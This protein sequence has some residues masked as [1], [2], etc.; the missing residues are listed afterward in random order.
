MKI[1]EFK[2]IVL[3]DLQD[4]EDH[5]KKGLETTDYYEEDNTLEEWYEQIDGYLEIRGT[6]W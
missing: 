6:E 4:F 2:K 3:Q 1:D 5:Y